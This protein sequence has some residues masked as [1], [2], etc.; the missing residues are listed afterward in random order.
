MLK[1]NKKGR[2]MNHKTGLMRGCVALL[3]LLIA[4][5]VV[6][7]EMS[8]DEVISQCYYKF[9]GNDQ[10]SHMTIVLKDK[11]GK[12]NKSEYLRLWK[13]YGGKG[14]VVDKVLLITEAPPHNKDLA[15]MR[16]GYSGESQK[17]TE[18][19]IYLPDLRKVRRLSPRDPETKDWVIKDD[20]LRLRER[21]E[22]DHRFKGVKTVDGKAY[23][24]VEFVPKNDPVYSK[25]VSWFSKTR[26]MGDCVQRQVDFY[27]QRGDLTKQQFIDWKQIGKAW[28]WHKVA[29]ESA[30][31]DAYIH[32]DIQNIE[33]NVGLGDAVFS[34]RTMKRGYSK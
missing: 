26:N 17:A 25:R 7:A 10:R 19:W 12:P 28:A 20:D 29:I 27:D 32:Y 15:F 11:G 3:P 31:S 30:T 18:Q 4:V 5:P 13:D 22:D 2:T 23:Y 16:W 14:G 34:D 9:A 21:H 33:V 1:G 8:A 6:A 24:V